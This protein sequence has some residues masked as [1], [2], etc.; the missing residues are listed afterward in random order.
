MGSVYQLSDLVNDCAVGVSKTYISKGAMETAKSDFNFNT[1]EEVLGFIGNGGLELPCLSNSK[2]WGNNPMP[3]NP[4]MVD[5]YHFYSGSTYGYIAFFYQP[6][7][8]KWVIKSFKKNSEPD[9][10]NLA[11]K[12]ALSKLR[13]QR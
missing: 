3:E 8:K 1:Q 2:P 11:F 4:I 12:E 6:T 10:R 13:S 5:A 7:T 9:T